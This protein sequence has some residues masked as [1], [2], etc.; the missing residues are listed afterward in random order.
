MT[1]DN[2]PDWLRKELDVRDWTQADLSRRSGVS[3]GQIARLLS[4]E[5]GLGPDSILAIAKALK[6]PPEEVYR[7]AGLLPPKS[8][9]DEL[10][11]KIHHIFDE[12]PPEEQE[13]VIEYARMRH[14]LAE[15]KTRYDVNKETKGKTKPRPATAEK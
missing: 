15:E 5:R 10:I 9:R 7:A 6:L 2:F 12:L 1:V 14:R 4:G 3:T 8:E 11:E 13:N